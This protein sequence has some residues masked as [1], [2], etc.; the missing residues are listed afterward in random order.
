MLCDILVI[1]GSFWL[2]AL[3]RH[4]VSPIPL[5]L[6]LHAT[7]VLLVAPLIGQMLGTCQRIALPPP[8]ELKMLSLST[9]LGMT[10]LMVLLFAAQRGD[11]YSRLIVLGAWLLSLFALPLARS[12]LRRSMCRQHWWTSPVIV[13]GSKGAKELCATLEKHPER[14]LRPVA[15]F[16][17]PFVGTTPDRELELLVATHPTALVVLMPELC[18]GDLLGARLTQLGRMFRGILLVPSFIVDNPFVW[19]APRD[20]GNGT[21]LLVRQNLHDSR[22][23]SLK[24][25]LDLTLIALCSFFL[26]PFCLVLALCIKLDSPGPVFYRQE[27]IGQNGRRFFIYKFRTMAENAQEMLEQALASDPALNEEWRQTQKLKNDPRITKVGHLLRKTSLDELPQLLNVLGGQMSLVGPRPI[28][29][30]E[31]EKYRAAFEE[32]CRVKPG[33]TGFWQI[34]GRS[35]TCYDERVRLDQYYVSNWSVWFDIWI[36]AKTLPVVILGKGAY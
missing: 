13:L 27:R 36:L 34:S 29:E 15:S 32:Y 19:L 28:V 16:E 10:V 25:S 5:E 17:T 2:L 30:N 24:K 8:R 3:V 22:R 14:G 18:T 9:T 31:I 33:L 26:V 20:L 6:Y 35:D 21:G 23:L 12:F 1:T 4:Q 11:I 7:P